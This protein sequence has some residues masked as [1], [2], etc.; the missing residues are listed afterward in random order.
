MKAFP[1][2]V[3]M[4]IFSAIIINRLWSVR[5]PTLMGDITVITNNS[6]IEKYLP[7]YQKLL[8]LDY[9]GYRNHLY[10]V[11][12]FSIHFLHGDQTYRDEI[13][14]ALVYH[15]I[16][17]WT[18]KT[19]AYIEPSV[20][21]A[22]LDLGITQPNLSLIEDIIYWHHK[23][24]PFKGQHAQVVNAVRKADWVDFSFGVVHYGLS[25]QHVSK[26]R[27]AIPEAGFHDTLTQFTLGNRSHGGNFLK[28]L[29]EVLHIYRW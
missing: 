17:L 26:V 15:D 7:R 11:L 21:R 28:A 9:D 29:W 12:S 13:A 3:L 16:A 4:G 1:G 14:T 20:A 6:V 18:D 24:T 19:N 27:N 2:I 23:I 22:K 5:D 10:R 25:R 8:G